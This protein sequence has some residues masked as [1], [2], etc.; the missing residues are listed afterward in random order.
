[1]IHSLFNGTFPTAEVTEH[2]NS[3]IIVNNKL[4]K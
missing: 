4:E 1:L 3:M 2:E